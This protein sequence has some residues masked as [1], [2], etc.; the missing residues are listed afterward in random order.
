MWNATVSDTFRRY[1]RTSCTPGLIRGRRMVTREYCHHYDFERS[2]G[3]FLVVRGC[4][5]AFTQVYVTYGVPS[6]TLDVRN[7]SAT[8]SS[9]A[10]GIASG[11]FANYTFGNGTTEL[12]FVYIVEAGDATERLDYVTPAS[13]ALNAPFG[14]IVAVATL[15]PVYLRSLPEPGKE[16]SLGWNSDIQISGEV[17]LVEA[18]S[19]DSKFSLHRLDNACRSWRGINETL[20]LILH[21]D[22]SE[23]SVSSKRDVGRRQSDTSFLVIRRKRAPFTKVWTTTPNGTYGAAQMIDIYVGFRFPITLGSST[24]YLSIN[25]EA[26]GACRSD[27]SL[28]SFGDRYSDERCFC[29]VFS[30]Q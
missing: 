12:V 9:D 18:V 24:A 22:L 30:K 23:S 10:H 1:L 15:E 8:N 7:D 3:L 26:G 11:T 6:L 21:G 20:H 29:Y 16:G 17:L 13:E 14:S 27:T 28:I 4:S 5:Y 2:R 19:N 25:P